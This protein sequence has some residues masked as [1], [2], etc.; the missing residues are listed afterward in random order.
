M[1]GGCP[2]VSPWGEPCQ[3]GE[4]STSSDCV[5]RGT[6]DPADVKP[7]ATLLLERVSTWRFR[8]PRL[9]PAE[10]RRATVPRLPS[11]GAA[12]SAGQPDRI[13]EPPLTA[14]GV[15]ELLERHG[16]FVDEVPA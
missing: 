5:N 11:E 7:G 16:E 8:D 10:A 14:A 3:R 4:H 1:I 13:A 12:E 2:S 15:L 6:Y 9:A